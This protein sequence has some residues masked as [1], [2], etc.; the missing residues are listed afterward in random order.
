MIWATLHGQGLAAGAAEVW[1]QL[2]CC[3]RG[4]RREERGRETRGKV[5]R[6]RETRG[7]VSP[8]LIRPARLHLRRTSVSAKSPPCDDLLSLSVPTLTGRTT[9]PCA[10]LP[11]RHPQ[12]APTEPNPQC[13]PETRHRALLHAPTPREQELGLLSVAED[14]GAE[15][16]ERFKG[17]RSSSARVQ[18]A[19][20]RRGCS[21]GSSR[22]DGWEL[23]SYAER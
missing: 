8:L 21:E 20:T 4:E 2:T 15:G 10:F 7:K 23:S 3:K 22:L 19:S 1:V 18:G 12:P 11:L 14:D 17:R 5:E 16:W 13:S 9:R 6:G